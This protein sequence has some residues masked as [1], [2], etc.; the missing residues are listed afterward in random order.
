[1]SLICQ[2]SPKVPAPQPEKEWE[3][4]QSSVVQEWQ[5]WEQNVFGFLVR[6][7]NGAAYPIPDLKRN[8][9]KF[10][11]QIRFMIK[12]YFCLSKFANFYPTFVRSI[13]AD[14]VPPTEKLGQRVRL[15]EGQEWPPLN[16]NELIRL[17][18]GLLRYELCCRLVGLPSVA[19]SSNPDVFYSVKWNRAS[20]VPCDLW[21]GNPFNRLLPIDEVEEII[22]ASKYV[23][24]LY[25]SL[26]CGLCEEFHSDILDLNQ[27]RGADGKDTERKTAG[28][29]MSQVRVL[30]LRSLNTYDPFD[31]AE[32]MSRLGLVFLD[33]MTTSTPTERTELMR[34][35]F[36]NLPGYYEDG[37][38]SL[39]WGSAVIAHRERK[40]LGY[41][42]G[43][44][45]NVLI[46]TSSRQ[47]SDEVIGLAESTFR[48]RSLGWVFFDESTLHSLGL[49][50]DAKIRTISRWVR[51]EKNRGLDWLP[52][53]L[54]MPQSVLS[55]R[56]SEEEWKQ[57]GRY[58]VKDRRNDYQAHSRFVAGAR[59]LVDFTS[60]QLPQID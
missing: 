17:Q 36:S 13:A 10:N 15:Q 27:G 16:D 14:T 48:L 54:A 44:R 9:T 51:K 39:D 37:F 53:K 41:G 50:H 31:W 59:A 23:R 4:V 19:V 24:D 12:L 25:R 38:L 5:A 42:V 49:P 40:R 6:H 30:D 56:F 2:I 8:V 47:S 45:C 52:L 33:R 57:L 3:K 55:A 32:S 35:V 34:T 43:P 1:M 22:C 11:A 20:S 21:V 60:T 18:R 7:A 28:H 26:R 29:W 46:Q 58:S